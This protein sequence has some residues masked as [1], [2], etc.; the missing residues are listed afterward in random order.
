MLLAQFLVLCLLL[1]WNG[2]RLADAGNLDCENLVLDGLPAVN[3][4]FDLQRAVTQE[5]LVKRDTPPGAKRGG[6][7]HSC[8]LALERA[9]FV[10]H[11]GASP[12]VCP[13]QGC[14]GFGG[15][16]PARS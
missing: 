1:F 7:V 13:L 10:D 6:C 8:G 9:N 3:G 15:F 11:D 12:G 5:E 2:L 14:P 16:S 4:E